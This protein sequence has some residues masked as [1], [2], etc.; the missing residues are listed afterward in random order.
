MPGPEEHQLEIQMQEPEA[1]AQMKHL[2]KSRPQTGQERG[3]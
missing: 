1:G 2:P 3:F